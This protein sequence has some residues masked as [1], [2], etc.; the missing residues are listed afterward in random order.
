MDEMTPICQKKDLPL[1]SS[2][3]CRPESLEP[4]FGLSNAPGTFCRALGL[5]LRGL[6]WKSVVSFLDDIV[7]LGRS[8][9]D[10]M[11]NMEQ[12]LSRF[13]DFKLKLKPSKCELLKRDIICSGSQG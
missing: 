13:R 2:T 10:H 5:V 8:F 9:E 11:K 1:G 6:S 12:V 3:T 7:I 4:P